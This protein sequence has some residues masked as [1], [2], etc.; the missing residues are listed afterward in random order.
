MYYKWKPRGSQRSRRSLRR[1]IYMG[2][3]QVTDD[4]D[5][6]MVQTDKLFKNFK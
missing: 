2:P 3:K 6:V 4:N 5:F 1:R